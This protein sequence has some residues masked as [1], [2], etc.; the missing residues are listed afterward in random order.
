ME[1]L[2]PHA[3]TT[4]LTL[5]SCRSQCTLELVLRNKRSQCN[6]RKPMHN[7]KDPVKSKNIFKKRTT[8]ILKK[9]VVLM[10]KTY[11]Q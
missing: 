3:T 11:Y 9:L 5:H 8:K 7:N 1:Q 6:Q 4:E 10:T 2:I